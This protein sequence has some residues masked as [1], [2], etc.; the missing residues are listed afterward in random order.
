MICRHRSW[1]PVARRLSPAAVQVY[2]CV[3]PTATPNGQTT[4]LNCR[5]CPFGPA[6]FRLPW[7]GLGDLVAWALKLIRIKPKPGCGCEVT[8]DRWNRR[9]PFRWPFRTWV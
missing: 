4:P 1:R 2:R 6:R 5:A 7:R 9:F 8:Q 3:H